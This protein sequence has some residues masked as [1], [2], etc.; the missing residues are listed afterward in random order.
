MKFD[1]LEPRRCEDIKG[2]LSTRKRPEKFRDFLVTGPWWSEVQRLGSS[3]KASEI[4][5]TST[6]HFRKKK[7]KESSNC[8]N[9]LSDETY[10]DGL[11]ALIAVVA[12]CAVQSQCQEFEVPHR[13]IF[14]WKMY[15]P[16]AEWVMLRVALNCM[17]TAVSLNKRHEVSPYPASRKLHHHFRREIRT[18][19]GQEVFSKQ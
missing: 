9:H 7:K 3:L 12:L 5:R 19:K 4:F 6:S 18:S 8:H 10:W 11:T 15:D 14:L 1:G 2:I 13:Y 17:H 16:Q